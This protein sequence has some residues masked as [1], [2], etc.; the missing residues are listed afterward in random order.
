MI[1]HNYVSLPEGILSGARYGSPWV[2]VFAH[3][4][5]DSP[6]DWQTGRRRY[7]KAVFTKMNT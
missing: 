5:F 4:A 3:D 7:V 1:F 2:L 6:S